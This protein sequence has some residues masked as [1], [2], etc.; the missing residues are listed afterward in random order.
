MQFDKS[1]VYTALNAEEL[2]IG[3]KVLLA[4]DITELKRL[5]KENIATTKLLSIN[6]EKTAYRFHGPYKNDDYMSYC[7][8]DLIAPPVNEI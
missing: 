4:D 8:A 1:K 3:S 2:K 7:F 6:D 5:V